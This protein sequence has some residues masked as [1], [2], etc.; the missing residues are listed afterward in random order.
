MFASLVVLMCISVQWTAFICTYRQQRHVFWSC[1]WGK[2]YCS[3]SVV[4]VDFAS[5]HWVHSLCLDFFV[6]VLDLFACVSIVLYYICMHVSL[7]RLRAIWMTNHPLQCFDTVGWV[8]RPAKVS[9][10][11][12]LYCV[13]WPLNL[14]QPRSRVLKPCEIWWKFQ[15]SHDKLYF[16]KGNNLAHIRS[17]WWRK[18]EIQWV[19]AP[20]KLGSIGE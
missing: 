4:G 5:S 15:I 17:H 1:T 2:C 16:D 11:K 14:T 6:C 12:D 10:P 20:C 8:I 3:L 18:T 7:V 9:S 13:K 19:V